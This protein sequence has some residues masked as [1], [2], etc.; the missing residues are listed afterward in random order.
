LDSFAGDA[1]GEKD[2]ISDG[3]LVHW[4]NSITCDGQRSSM[5]LTNHYMAII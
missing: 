5:V 4:V 3:L 1:Q 2:F